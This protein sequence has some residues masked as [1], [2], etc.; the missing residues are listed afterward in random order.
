M[1]I[2][3]EIFAGILTCIDLQMYFQ[4]RLDKLFKRKREFARYMS[5][6]Y[7]LKGMREKILIYEDLIMFKNRL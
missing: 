3:I 2:I 4:I 5:I 7:H 6:D 1:V